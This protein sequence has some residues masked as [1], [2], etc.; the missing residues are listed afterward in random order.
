MSVQ[1]YKQPISNLNTLLFVLFCM[2]KS[3]K[4]RECNCFKQKYMNFYFHCFYYVHV[5]A[6]STSDPLCCELFHDAGQVLG[7]HVMALLP[8]ISQ[9]TKKSVI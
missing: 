9:V 8:K 6:I 5:V 3:D 1:C 2:G 4:L 7:R